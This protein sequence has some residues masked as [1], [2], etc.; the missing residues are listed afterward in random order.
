MGYHCPI[1]LIC[2]VS[3]SSTTHKMTRPTDYNTWALQPNGFP[4]TS[5]CGPSAECQRMPATITGRRRPRSIITSP[6]W[7][8]VTLISMMLFVASSASGDIVGTDKND[9]EG[10][11]TGLY[12]SKHNDGYENAAGYT[13]RDFFDKSMAPSL[14]GWYVCR[15]GQG[16]VNL[17]VYGPGDRVEHSRAQTWLKVSYK[18]YSECI[19]LTRRA[20]PASEYPYR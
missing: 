13:I 12:V 17:G 11:H 10:L 20:P 14:R 3:Q 16:G 6:R 18:K 5:S 2:L 7:R 4:D 1:P 19:T 9:P 8:L 15:P